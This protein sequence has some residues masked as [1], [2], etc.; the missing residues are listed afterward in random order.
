MAFRPSSEVQQQQRLG[1]Q[2]LIIGP[3]PYPYYYYDQG[4]SS[5]DGG[6]TPQPHQHNND[7]SPAVPAAGGSKASAKRPK[8]A[9]VATAGAY[10]SLSEMSPTPLTPGPKRWSKEEENA[11]VLAHVEEGNRWGSIAER[12]TGGRT[13]LEVKVRVC[14]GYL[15]RYDRLDASYISNPPFGRIGRW[16]GTIYLHAKW[17]MRH[18]TPNVLWNSH[19]VKYNHHR[20]VVFDDHK[21]MTPIN[22][23]INSLT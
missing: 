10:T 3:H 20:S 23:D 1:P 5:S 8:K 12:L 7:D 16:M 21:M 19:H 14:G 17:M 2:P 6:D 4:I 9:S 22:D 15:P 18:V 13:Q 11:L